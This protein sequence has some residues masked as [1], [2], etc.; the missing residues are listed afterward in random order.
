MTTAGYAA[1]L[2]VADAVSLLAANK[3]A[4]IIAGG[5]TLLVGASR[6]AAAG[7]LLVDLRKVPGLTTIESGADGLV[8]GA[9]ATLNAIAESDVVRRTSPVL[10]EAARLTGD[11]QMRNRA[12]LGGSLASAQSADTDLAAVILALGASVSITG[13][14]G[15]RTVDIDALLTKP[16]GRDEVITGVVVPVPAASGGAAY[17]SQRHPATLAA[18]CGVAA[19]VT[20]ANGVVASSRIALIGATT[21]PIRLRAAEQALAGK[22]PDAAALRAAVSQ[23]LKGATLRADLFGSAEYRAHLA[24]VLTARAVTRAAQAPMGQ[25]VA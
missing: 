9:M 10:A 22:A 5:S 19:A 15:D 12:T 7:S 1:P 6:A 17:E 24:S 11:A 3:T 20:L 16:V 13:P 18:L 25:G 14:R 23:D 2:T 8:L 21:S 4:R